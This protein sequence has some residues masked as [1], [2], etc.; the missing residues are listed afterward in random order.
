MIKGFDVFEGKH[1]S[2][3]KFCRSYVCSHA[4]EV[5]LLNEFVG[6]ERKKSSR[7]ILNLTVCWINM[8]LTWMPLEESIRRD[9]IRQYP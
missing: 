8:I 3:I 2:V 7:E 5:H 6:T 4:G 9:E 1:H